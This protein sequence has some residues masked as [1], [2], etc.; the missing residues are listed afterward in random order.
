MASLSLPLWAWVV[1]YAAVLLM[2]IADLKLFGKKG[3]HEVGIRESLIMTA[4]WIGVSLLFDAR[5]CSFHVA[6][7]CSLKDILYFYGWLWNRKEY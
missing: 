7:G 4:V 6:K 1:F 3:Q 2:L 5:F